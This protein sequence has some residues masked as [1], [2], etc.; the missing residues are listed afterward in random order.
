[1]HSHQP[2]LHGSS[3]VSGAD[4]VPP[5]LKLIPACPASSCVVC[6]T[7]WHNSHVKLPC[8][9]NV[10]GLLDDILELKPH[11]FC[12]V[13]RLWNRIYDRVMGTIRESETNALTS[14]R[15]FRQQSAEACARPWAH[16]CRPGSLK[17]QCSCCTPQNAAGTCS[18]MSSGHG[19]HW[20]ARSAACW[21]VRQG[22]GLS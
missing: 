2:C 14:C 11:V 20:C 16:N 17:A 15:C 12:S 6:A 9:G 7:F 1:M 19:L 4:L 21:S 10:E 22:R 18:H 3:D 5:A 13:P 8:R